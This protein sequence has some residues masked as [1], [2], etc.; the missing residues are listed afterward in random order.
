MTA[1][2]ATATCQVV[3]GDPRRHVHLTL[4]SVDG[5]PIESPWR[6]W[7]D[8]VQ[9]TWCIRADLRRLSATNERD[10]CRYV[11]ADQD[12]SSRPHDPRFVGRD[13]P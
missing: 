4:W 6:R 13:R 5:K 10:A 11:D 7:A 9:P 3:S 2:D 1:L 12:D 8:V